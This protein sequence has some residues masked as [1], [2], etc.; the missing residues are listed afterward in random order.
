ME[1]YRK[2]ACKDV[3]LRTGAAVLYGAPNSP[4]PLTPRR[5]NQGTG[6]RVTRPCRSGHTHL[7]RCC[8]NAR[9]TTSRRSPLR[10]HVCTAKHSQAEGGAA[11]GGQH[12]NA[13]PVL[14]PARLHLARRNLGLTGRQAHALATQRLWGTKCMCEMACLRKAKSKVRGPQGTQ[15]PAVPA[16]KVAYNKNRH[17]ALN[18]STLSAA[19][20]LVRRY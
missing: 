4:S 5:R 19:G 11:L 17:W 12:T 10:H 2:I 16:A 20:G 13:Q 8:Q 3:S 9:E 1:E 7:R 18:A 14:Q 15:P 6:N